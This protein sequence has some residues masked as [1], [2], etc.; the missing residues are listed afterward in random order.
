MRG[1]TIA[2]RSLVWR[3]RQSACVGSFAKSGGFVVAPDLQAELFKRGPFGSVEQEA[4]LALARTTALLSSQF[5]VL[6]KGSGLTQASY[7]AL[8]ILRGAGPG[9]RMCHEIGQHLVTPVPDVTR[10]IDRLTSAGLA[11]RVRSTQDKRVTFVHIT[12][13]GLTLLDQLEKP[14]AQLHESHFAGIP[15]ARVREVIDVLASAR[16]L[17]R[18]INK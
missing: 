8:R 2:A 16:D 6:F 10:L 4:Y 5:D 9:G 12:P 11:K 18:A 3:L 13:K 14:V 17:A 1:G 15:T 7:N